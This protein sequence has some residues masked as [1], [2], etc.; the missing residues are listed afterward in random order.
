MWDKYTSLSHLLLYHYLNDKFTTHEAIDH[1]FDM[2]LE[3]MQKG[4]RNT[5][6]SVKGVL[7]GELFNA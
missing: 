2:V 6:R 1:K 7:G 4:E 5:K 3:Y